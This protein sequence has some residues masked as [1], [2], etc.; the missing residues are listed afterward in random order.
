MSRGDLRRRGP[1]TVNIG[2]I[3]AEL[4]Q[5]N[6]LGK[7][8]ESD[9]VPAATE[10]IQITGDFNHLGDGHVFQIQGDDPRNTRMHQD[11][12]RGILDQSR[13]KFPYRCRLH[14]NIEPGFMCRFHHRRL[15]R[16][17]QGDK[18]ERLF[19][20][21]GMNVQRLLGHHPPRRHPP[22]PRQPLVFHRRRGHGKADEFLLRPLQ[23]ILLARIHVLVHTTGTEQ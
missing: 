15:C 10:I 19:G 2:I 18:S 11:V 16:G 9:F 8:L 21:H 3:Q 14:L 12:I 23:R 5:L 20:R 6:F 1:L 4:T 7:N 17:V 22:C 13:K